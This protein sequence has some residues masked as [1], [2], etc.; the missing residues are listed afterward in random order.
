MVVPQKPAHARE[1]RCVWFCL[2]CL[3]IAGFVLSL[4]V[5][6]EAWQQR[7]VENNHHVLRT[8]QRPITLGRGPVE[9]STS[10]LD[11][12]PAV[13]SRMRKDRAGAAIQDIF[14]AH[15]F[16]FSED[17]PYGGVCIEPSSEEDSSHQFLIQQ[18]KSLIESLGLGD[19][20]PFA[21]PRDRL[22]ILLRSENYRSQDT[23][24]FTES[25]LQNI[26]KYIKYSKT[27][28][29]HE[30]SNAIDVVVHIRRGD[31]DPC[32][33]PNR[34]LPNSHYIKVIDGLV[35]EDP[36]HKEFNVTVFSE[37]ESFEPWGS[38]QEKFRLNF[39]RNLSLVWTAMIN[40]DVLVMSRSS[41]S[42][43]PAVLSRGTVLYTPFWHKPLPHWRVVDED[44]V[45]SIAPEVNQLNRHCKKKT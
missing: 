17:S 30:V 1:K 9:V 33:H 36:K 4:L 43:V 27:G 44:I 20:L 2:R 18:T 34:Y 13:Y 12:V 14:M 40:A 39:E 22:D 25:W 15:A 19:I 11:G 32:Q 45:K 7:D 3:T 26:Q 24:V 28:Q 5:S 16:A 8:E 35:N 29:H 42:L 21:C 37:D 31:V 38:L 41:F 6:K 23:A 10:T